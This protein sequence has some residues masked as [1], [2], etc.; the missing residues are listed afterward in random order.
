[1]GNNRPA[2]A[3]CER[4]AEHNGIGGGWHLEVLIRE[5]RALQAEYQKAL[6][7][8]IAF[9]RWRLGQGDPLMERINR[10]GP[11]EKAP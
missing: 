8:A 10:S 6:D 3:I 7:E 9:D 1:V 4:E 2:S 5:R 11:F